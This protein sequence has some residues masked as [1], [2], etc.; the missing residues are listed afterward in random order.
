MDATFPTSAAPRRPLVEEAAW[1]SPTALDFE[2][3][4][5]PAW[6]ARAAAHGLLLDKANGEWAARSVR[7]ADF[8]AVP[9]AAL[10]TLVAAL[11]ASD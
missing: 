9:D 6:V 4:D 2:L 7:V 1:R 8:P 3:D 5:P 10:E 11:P